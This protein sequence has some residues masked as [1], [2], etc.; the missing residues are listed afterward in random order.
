MDP[1]EKQE[2]HHEAWP[3]FRRAFFVVFILALLY[4]LTIFIGTGG[5]AGSH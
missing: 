4:M 1:E 5:Q 3:G 2:L